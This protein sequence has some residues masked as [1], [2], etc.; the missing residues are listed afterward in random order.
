MTCDCCG[1]KKR[2]LEMFYSVGD[3]PEK[4][5]LCSDCREVV[6]H[7]R[8]DRISGESELY[9]I[10]QLQLRKRAKNPSE[11]FLAWKNANYPD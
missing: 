8:T 5:R 4:L 3:G 6:E 2:L 11:A 10:H 1:A 9:G 7:L